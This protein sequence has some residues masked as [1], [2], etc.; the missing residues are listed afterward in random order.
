[1]SAEQSRALV[2]MLGYC[3]SLREKGAAPVFPPGITF[4]DVWAAAWIANRPLYKTAC[5]KACFYLGYEINEKL[6]EIYNRALIHYKYNPKEKKTTEFTTYFLFATKRTAANVR[7]RRGS[8]E[9]F[10][11]RQRLAPLHAGLSAREN[12]TAAANLDRLRA[13]VG[14]LLAD[15]SL[16]NAEQRAFLQHLKLLD[17]RI[18]REALSQEWPAFNPRGAYRKLRQR[19][20]SLLP[21]IL[22]PYL[23]DQGAGRLCVQ[24]VY[25]GDGLKVIGT[26]KMGS[27]KMRCAFYHPSNGRKSDI[28]QEIPL[29]RLNNNG[30]VLDVDFWRHDPTFQRQ[31]LEAAFYKKPPLTAAS[32]VPQSP[33]DR[34]KTS[35]SPVLPALPT[36]KII[37]FT[38]APYHK[39]KPLAAPTPALAPVS[40]PKV[41][42][43]LIAEKKFAA[44]V[45]H[46]SMSGSLALPYFLAV[47]LQSPHHKTWLRTADIIKYFDVISKAKKISARY[48]VMERLFHELYLRLSG[49]TAKSLDIPMEQAQALTDDHLL[50]ASPPG[51]GRRCWLLSPQAVGLLA[52]AG[53]LKLRQMR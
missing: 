49:D 31:Q 38:P 14:A 26:V 9:I 52:A 40:S 47:K 51:V 23:F 4:N 34:G 17:G 13:D 10:N 7:D 37:S 30:W 41:H 15:S 3:N 43:P 11:R 19:S 12:P 39:S 18:D 16:S 50:T 29:S 45:A 20:F 44:V 22:I 1:M 36:V 42:E 6:E 28:N 25:N 8:D 48:S 24:E 5:S 27:V 33:T 35:A 32:V 53:K 2:R 21:P 46:L